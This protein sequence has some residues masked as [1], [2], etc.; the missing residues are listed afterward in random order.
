MDKVFV[1][2]KRYAVE[3]PWYM[4][5]SDMDYDYELSYIGIYKTLEDAFEAER[6]YLKENPEDLRE[7]LRVFEAPFGRIPYTITPYWD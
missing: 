3:F 6:E 1:L 2:V 7:D 4:S 5:V